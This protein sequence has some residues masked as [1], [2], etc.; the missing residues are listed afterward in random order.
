MICTSDQ[1][2]MLISP[3][4]DKIS[5]LIKMNET[6]KCKMITYKTR[7]FEDRNDTFLAQLLITQ[8]SMPGDVWN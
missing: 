6:D 3:K 4:Q 2:I 7:C 8:T 5:C 1:Y